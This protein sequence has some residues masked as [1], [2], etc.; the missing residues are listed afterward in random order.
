MKQEI[1]RIWMQIRM[2]IIVKYNVDIMCRQKKPLQ[3]LLLKLLKS[4]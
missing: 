3:N 1:I 2:D 4:L